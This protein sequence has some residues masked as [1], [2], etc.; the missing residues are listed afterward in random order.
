MVSPPRRCGGP[1]RRSAS[2]LLPLLSSWLS[3][4]E[5][6]EKPGRSRGSNSV[7]QL[8]R[9]GGGLLGRPEGRAV[10]FGL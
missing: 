9:A 1:R 6:A 10:Q 2:L 8:V 5:E 7:T 3:V 4:L